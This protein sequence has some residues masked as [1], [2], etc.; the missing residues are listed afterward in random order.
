MTAIAV[1]FTTSGGLFIGAITV[2]AW[3]TVGGGI[4]LIGWLLPD[5]AVFDDT[6]GVLFLALGPLAL[7]Q[8]GKAAMALAQGFY[9][10]GWLA[11]PSYLVSFT[12]F[13]LLPI[14]LTL[15]SLRAGAY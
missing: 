8:G 9:A 13:T 14:L 12:F 15:A 5:R 10:P 2:I 11:L 3:Y 4:L 7:Y 1:V 6:L